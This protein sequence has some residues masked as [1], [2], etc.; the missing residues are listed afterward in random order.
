MYAG[1]CLCTNFLYMHTGLDYLY[2]CLRDCATSPHIR[3]RA[4]NVNMCVMHCMFCFGPYHAHAMVA[5]VLFRL[6]L[7][8]PVPNDACTP[9]HLHVYV[10]GDV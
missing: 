9:L 4:C 10:C 7:C 3:A 1:Y 2:T 6:Q 5:D 8:A